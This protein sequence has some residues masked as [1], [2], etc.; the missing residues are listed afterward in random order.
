MYATTVWGSR[1]G[2]AEIDPAHRDF[3][4]VLNASK[5]RVLDTIMASEFNVLAQLLSRIAAG[6]FSTRD[7]AADRLRAALAA[8][9]DS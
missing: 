6:H 5:V 2:W 9:T 7:Y 4:A 8:T 1:E 3:G